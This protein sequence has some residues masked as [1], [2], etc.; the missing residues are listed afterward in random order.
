MNN[1][2][3]REKKSICVN[4]IRHNLNSVLKN[5]AFLSIFLVQQSKI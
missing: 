2:N 4:D 5:C 3:I 1:M